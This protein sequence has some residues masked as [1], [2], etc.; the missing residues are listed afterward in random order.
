MI[1]GGGLT[2]VFGSSLVGYDGA[3]PLACIV[4]AF[5]ACI[6]WKMQGWSCTHVSVIPKLI[7]KSLSSRVQRSSS[8]SQ[9]PV[10]DVFSSLWI[11]LQP[12]LFG[13]VGAEIDLKV[14]NLAHI[15]EGLA[16]IL[17]GLLVSSFR[18]TE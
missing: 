3:G 4:A 15:F 1:G 6:I 14:I 2:M 7:R 12:A 17:G 9:N 8:L 13:L 5:T 16:I 18:S 10:R 11:L